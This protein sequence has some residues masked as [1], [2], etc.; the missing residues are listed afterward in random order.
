MLTEKG[1]VVVDPFAGSCVTGEVCQ[2]LGRKWICIDVVE[3]Y[4]RG[5]KA[6]FL[7]P[8]QQFAFEP[9]AAGRKDDES[10][11]YRIPH[12]GLLWKGAEG[13]ELPVDGGRRRPQ[14]RTEHD[15]DR[16]AE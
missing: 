11:Y 15:P 7:K 4:L 3:E 1:D 9:P 10:N 13:D 16:I 6:R 2:R 12:P 8:V 5:A 14:S